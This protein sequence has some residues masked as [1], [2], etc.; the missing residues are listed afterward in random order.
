MD[1]NHFLTLSKTLPILWDSFC[2]NTPASFYLVTF[3]DYYHFT[4]TVT[5]PSERGHKAFKQNRSD[6]C[7]KW[8]LFEWDT[9]SSILCCFLCNSW[10]NC[11]SWTSYSSWVNFGI[12]SIQT[13]IRG[14]SLLAR[15]CYYWVTESS[16]VGTHLISKK[17][18]TKLSE[19]IGITVSLRNLSQ[20]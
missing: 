13:K 1:E 15:A 3:S 17:Q 4:Y 8:N 11:A 14:L 16:W 20:N 10:K 9:R 12:W 18:K 2:G 6:S 5:Y 19:K 7:N